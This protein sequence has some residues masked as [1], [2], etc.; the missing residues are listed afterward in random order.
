M[1]EYV[2]EESVRSDGAI[3]WIVTD[4]AR[5]GGE[6]STQSER[7]GLEFCLR[8]GVSPGSIVRVGSRDG[9]HR[10]YD[11]EGATQRIEQLGGRAM[12][13][14]GATNPLLGAL[15]CADCSQDI[16]QQNPDVTTIGKIKYSAMLCR[17]CQV[18]RNGGIKE[19]RTPARRADG[20]KVEKVE[21]VTSDGQVFSKESAARGHQHTLTAP[22]RRNPNAQHSSPAPE[23][24]LLGERFIIGVGTQGNEFWWSD[25]D[26]A[27]ITTQ[28]TYDGM[29]AGTPDATQR[30]IRELRTAR[31]EGRQVVKA[32]VTHNPRRPAGTPRPRKGDLHDLVERTKR[33]VVQIATMSDKGP[34]PDGQVGELSK[35]YAALQAEFDEAMNEVEEI[36][37]NLSIMRAVMF[38]HSDPRNARDAIA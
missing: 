22:P 19:R 31:R 16:S 23:A 9:F 13:N 18:Q 1:I 3:R 25:A 8:Q 26:K 32:Q 2:V 30:Q 6:F 35:S 36:K 33:L 27:W 34:I 21:W 7:E 5:G 37:E 20:V 11:H 10:D 29:R 12:A 15:A 28:A 38:E 24:T 17:P 14:N 4:L